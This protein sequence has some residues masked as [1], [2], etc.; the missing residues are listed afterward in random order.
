MIRSTHRGILAGVLLPLLAGAAS[1][2]GAWNFETARIG[3]VF[4]ASTQQSCTGAML[5]ADLVLTAAHCV[6]EA[7]NT[8]PVATRQITFSLQG[9]QEPHQVSSI[10]DIATHPE[11]IREDV[12]SRDHVALDL[13][14]LR[15]AAPIPGLGDSLADVE[16][17]QDVLAVLPNDSDGSLSPEPC[18]ATFEA[19]GV[20]VLD[21]AKPEGA[22]GAPVYGL[23][24]NG[25]RIVGVVSASG[26]KGEA[27]VT[28]AA[29]P[30]LY[31]TELEWAGRARAK[32][33]GY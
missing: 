20:I 30:A 7:G 19:K 29:N 1:G 11:F 32:P 27:I 26:E 28:F 31:L 23:F 5:G 3:Q 2:Q 18:S 10:S 25:R 12:P 33:T 17:R 8:V 21:C 15:L 14:L 16:A 24:E 9:A 6:I 13:A 4:N 22:S